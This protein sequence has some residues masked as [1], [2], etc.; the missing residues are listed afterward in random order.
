[1]TPDIALTFVLLG[2][3]AV[4]FAFEWFP[5]D[6]TALAGLAALVLFGLI[7]V[8]QAL[9]GF[10]NEV[11]MT[12]ACVFVIAG[13]LARSGL[14]QHLADGLL[15]LA[16]RPSLVSPLL[17]AVAAALSAFFSNTS[18]T[19]MLM[20]ATQRIAQRTKR[21]PSQLLMPLAFASILGGTCTLIGTSTNLAGASLMT[22]LGMA[23]FTLF[24]FTLVGVLITLAGIVYMALIGHRTIPQRDAGDLSDAYHVRDYLAELII[25]D[26][27]EAVGSTITSL[28]LRDRDMI[29]LA[30]VRDGKRLSAR[31]N[32][33]LAAGDKLVVHGT[34][35]ALLSAR[36]HP[37]YSIETQGELTDE[38]VATDEVGI[39][40]VVVIP[41]S[42]LAGRTLKQLRFIE[43]YGL[44]VLAIYRRGHAYPV[45]IDRTP[46]RV[47]DVLLVQGQQQRLQEL[48]A[49]PGLWLSQEVDS[50][51]ISTR[52]GLYALGA[53]V[54]AVVLT[55]TGLVAVSIA[56]LLATIAL[57]LTRC[58][59]MEEAY[60]SIEWRVII[61]IAS[62]SAFGVAMQQ[63]GTAAFVAD[64]IVSTVAPLGLHAT[65]AA[66]ALLAIILTQPMSNAAAALVLIPVAVSTAGMLGMD[67]RTFAVMVTLSAS[68]SFVTPLEPASLLVFG[69]GKYRFRDFALVGLPLTLIALVMLVFLVPVI[70][71]P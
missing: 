53:L 11:V 45:L 3:V 33:K 47:G 6:L 36:D 40:E 34:R 25:D 5:I 52:K 55:A 68:L 42:Q 10:A 18:A 48:L 27:S 14:T 65:L 20:P 17:M 35:D 71:P 7:D 28:K 66:F 23:P 37:L 41:Q 24:E 39:A 8:D 44:M 12:L 21:P 62:M 38:D 19:G 61:L 51:P 58:T 50:V 43:R 29:P 2:L 22:R 15:N 67:P 49:D 56:F 63:S 16:A 54:G 1:M 70:W 60:A 13:T 57:V 4:S 59:T 31:G 9:A 46:L 69:V 26:D 64:G 30:V 32:R